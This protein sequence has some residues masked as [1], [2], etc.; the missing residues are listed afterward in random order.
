MPR[1]GGSETV[2]AFGRDKQGFSALIA[3][4]S[5]MREVLRLASQVARTDATILIQGESG[6][7]KEVLAR[8]LHEESHQKGGPFIKVDCAAL[9]ETL[10]E[11]ELFGHEKG[12]F[13]DA[14]AKKLGRLELAH[15]GTLFLD[16]VGGMSPPLQAKILR[17]LEE[18]AFERVGG[19]ET[20]RVD[21][22]IIAATNRNLKEA[23]RENRFREDLYFRLNVFPL[24]LPPLRRRR[25]DISLLAKTFLAHYARKYEKAVRGLNQEAFGLLL[26]YPWP[27]NVRELEHTIERAVLLSEGPILGPEDLG[28]DLLAVGLEDSAEDEGMTLS[29]LEREYIKRVLRKVRGHKGRA[30]KILG[31]NRKTLL[32]KR[33]RYG[34]D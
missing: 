29:E 17:V 15:E 34:L 22:R 9:P 24:R 5:S 7:G 14:F 11:N 27:G 13:T 12:A 4:S 6:T 10:L 23:L 16:E 30:A 3:A 1:S 32:E 19:T 20:I 18:R 26:R 25:E 21:V 8:A 33:K 2:A 31:I 28:L